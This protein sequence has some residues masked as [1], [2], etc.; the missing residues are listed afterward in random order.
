M[1]VP[2]LAC[3]LLV[4]TSCLLTE[5]REVASSPPPLVRVGTRQR[6]W[7]VHRSSELVGMV[8]LFHEHGEARDSVYV[9]RNPWHQDLGLI[10]GLGRAFR[11]VPHREEPSWVGSG[12]IALGAERILGLEGQCLLTEVTEGAQPSAPP[13]LAAF[14]GSETSAL[15]LERNPGPILVP[16]HIDGLRRCG[17]FAQYQR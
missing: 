13:A 12:T 7:E 6:M 3:A 17:G 11:Y 8:V 16:A 4:A 15:S 5:T 10:D 2:L 9:V 1:K 14:E